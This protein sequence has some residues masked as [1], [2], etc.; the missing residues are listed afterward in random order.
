MNTSQLQC[1][2]ECDD[3]L[4]NSIIGVYAA[5][6]LPKGARN[7]PYGF[8]SNTDIHFKRGQHWCA[9]FQNEG[10]DLEFF[11]SYG[12]SPEKKKKQCTFQTMV[13]QSRGLC[14]NEQTSNSK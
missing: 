1:M 9:F 8:I 10:G 13:K 4:R 7:Y 2:I 14:S 6:Q 3:L 11:D 12:R 5:D